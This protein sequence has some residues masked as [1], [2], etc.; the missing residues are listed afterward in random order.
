MIL[1]ITKILT[2]PLKVYISEQINAMKKC[3]LIVSKEKLGETFYE[4]DFLNCN[5]FH[6][7]LRLF[8]VLPN[9]SFTTSETIA[10]LLL[11]NMVFT[12]CRTT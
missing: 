3:I 10:G 4:L 7:I 9:F 2:V 1:K 11:I 12:S 8:D 5:Q 6:N